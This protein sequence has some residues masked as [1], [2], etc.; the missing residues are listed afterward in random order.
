MQSG[1]FSAILNSV[2][3]LADEHWPVSPALQE[4]H[5]ESRKDGVVA[6]LTGMAGGNHWS[7]SILCQP[8]LNQ[9]TFELAC[10]YKAAPGWMGSVYQTPEWLEVR[11]GVQ[12]IKASLPHS[13]ATLVASSDG[14]V[15]MVPQFED[16]EKP[17][18]DAPWT[19][20]FRS[21]VKGFRRLLFFAPQIMPENAGR[22]RLWTYQMQV[23]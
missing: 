1:N 5:I 16:S 17:A 8:E 6:F 3:G 12:K 22:T 23:T 7:A 19:A 20:S 9:A 2:E 10:R 11:H 14:L 15:G 4:L 13:S 21:Q 18:P